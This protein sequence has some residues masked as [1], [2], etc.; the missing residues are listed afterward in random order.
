M[1]N[2]ATP[3]KEYRQALKSFGSLDA[4]DPDQR[5]MSGNEVQQHDV[6]GQ[7]LQPRRVERPRLRHSAKALLPILA[8]SMALSH[9]KMLLILQAAELNR[10]ASGVAQ[11]SSQLKPRGGA[12]LHVS[13]PQRTVDAHG[14]HSSRKVIQYS[15]RALNNAKIDAS[16][17]TWD[18]A[19]K[20]DANSVKWDGVS[21]C[22]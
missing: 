10:I 22:C 20:I 15:D 8:L 11:T 21:I 12:A 3:F 7:S 1:Q 17:V 16:A 18:A 13:N 2:L 14:T 6:A 19:P 9:L 4:G 5:A